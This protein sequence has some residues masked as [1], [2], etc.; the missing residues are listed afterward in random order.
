MPEYL[1]NQVHYGA[2]VQQQE[3]DELAPILGYRPEDVVVADAALTELVKQNKPEHDTQL[4]QLFHRRYL[5]RCHVL[6]GP[7]APA[8]HLVLMQVEPL[9]D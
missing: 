3:L 7:N 4:T 8:D 9:L 5:R 6:A 2:W 1:R